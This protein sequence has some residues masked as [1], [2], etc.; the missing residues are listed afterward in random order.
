MTVKTLL[1]AAL[2]LALGMTAHADSTNCGNVPLA[3]DGAIPTCPDYSFPA[4][5]TVPVVNDQGFSDFT[6]YEGCNEENFALWFDNSPSGIVYEWLEVSYYPVYEV[7]DNS[8]YLW[9]FPSEAGPVTF[10]FL[11]QSGGIVQFIPGTYFAADGNGGSS[12][13]IST[14]EPA[15]I[16]LL[17]SAI[18]IL[19][20]FRQYVKTKVA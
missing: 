17:L 16:P 9:Q 18:A 1:A 11:V 19:I 20:V 13:T 12:I 2:F 14:P 15:A 10:P 8:A 5:I 4:T 7:S 6:A 3:S